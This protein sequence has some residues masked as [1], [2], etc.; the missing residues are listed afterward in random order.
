MN[1]TD[2]A[3]KYQT[4]KGTTHSRGELG[5]QGYTEFYEELLGPW[6]ARHF[7]MLEIGVAQGG[8]LRMWRDFFLF[9]DIFGLDQSKA[10]V[11]GCTVVTGQQQDPAVLAVL[12]PFDL[13]VDDGGHRFSEHKASF[14]GLFPKMPSGGLYIIEDLH[15]P[16]NNGESR[17]YFKNLPN[18]DLECEGRVVVIRK[19]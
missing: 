17:E 9:A 5:P 16:F 14:E 10:S 12:P 3:N 19:D 6:K 8:S 7:R 18:A 13:V 15:A 11:P 2:L 4:D 1:L